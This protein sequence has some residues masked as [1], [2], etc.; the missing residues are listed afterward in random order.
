MD[1]THWGTPSRGAHAP[2]PLVESGLGALADRSIWQAIY[3]AARPPRRQAPYL[4][5]PNPRSHG[6]ALLFFSIFGNSSSFQ[7][8]ADEA[9]CYQ[10]G[11]IRVM[12]ST[13]VRVAFL[14]FI[15]WRCSN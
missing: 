14:L 4:A 2:Y 5:T 3:A 12:R 10:L 1:P 6:R 11:P 7:Q 13:Q 15:I 8:S 9:K